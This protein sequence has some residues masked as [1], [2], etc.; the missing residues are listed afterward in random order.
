MGSEN[1]PQTGKEALRWAVSFLTA[2]GMEHEISWTEGKLLLGKVWQKNVVQ[3]ITELDES[4]DRKSWERYR[5][6]VKK[7]GNNEPLHYLLGEKEFMSLP[8]EVSAAVLIPRWD[9]ETLVNEAINILKDKGAAKIL[10]IG[11]GSGAIALSLAYY[12]PLVSVIATDISEEAL[13]VARK[14]AI[15]LGVA[16]RVEFI[17]GDLFKP[18]NK[19]ERFDLIVSNPPYIDAEEMESLPLDVRKEP[20]LALAGGQDGLEYYRR[21]SLVVK[22]YLKYD[23]NLLLE[24]GWKQGKTVAKIMEEKGLAPVKII[25]DMEGRDRVIKL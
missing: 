1:E 22:E 20:A 6:L 13:T 7:R 19:K 15:N 9:T 10:D 3:L 14:N 12:L 18:I 4:L 5:A 11:T 2:T 23:G 8:F 16:D 17:K 21:I 24:I 25:C